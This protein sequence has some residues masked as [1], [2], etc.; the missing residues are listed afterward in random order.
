MHEVGS[1]TLQLAQRG[2]VEAYR[3][4]VEEFEKPV[5]R[6]VYRLVGSRF[7]TDVEDITQDIFVKLFR[8]LPTFD[9][10]RGT[11]LSSWVSRS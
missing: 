2:D 11:R 1:E 4:L 3:A 7:P 5:F 10:T 8:A 9:P 6:T